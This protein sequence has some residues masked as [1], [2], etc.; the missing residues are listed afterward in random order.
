MTPASYDSQDIPEKPM[1]ATLSQLFV[2]LFLTTVMLALN[3]CQS[4]IEKAKRNASYSAYEFF[5]VEKR[6]LLKSRVNKARNEQKE[7]AE[8]FTSALD[9]LKAL[10]NFEGG[11]LERQYR[12]LQSAYDR[13]NEQADMVHAAVT[14]VDV[15]ASDLF[16]EWE[17]EIGEIQTPSL[18]DASRRKLQE[19]KQKSAALVGA[20]RK[21]EKTMA[22]VLSKLKDQVLFLKHNLNAEAIGSLK[23]ES[24]RIQNDVEKL[25]QDMNASIA[26]ADRFIEDLEKDSRGAP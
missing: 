13:A 10:T 24:V 25:L 2:L 5:G 22:P 7:A 16:E 6:D 18:R 3:S 20:L 9:R 19:T 23:T 4:A 11:A 17:K 26:A 15:T 14:K 8:N 12:S 1:R 21:S